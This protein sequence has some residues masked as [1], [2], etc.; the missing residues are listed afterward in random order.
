MY[1]FLPGEH[2][3]ANVTLL[4]RM[5]MTLG[6]SF[7]IRENNVTVATGMVT[8]LLPSVEIPAKRLDR[9]DFGKIFLK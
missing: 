8:K 4:Q 1:F 3:T 6:Q 9:V 2:N 5:V 7:T